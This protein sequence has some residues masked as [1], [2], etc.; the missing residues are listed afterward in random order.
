MRSK[1]IFN[2]LLALPMLFIGTPALA[3]SAESL[4]EADCLTDLSLT[5]AGSSL[6]LGPS[7]Y[8]R[9]DIRQNLSDIAHHESAAARSSEIANTSLEYKKLREQLKKEISELYVL[10]KQ[11]RELSSSES[12]KATELKRQIA[13]AKLKSFITNQ[14]M[15]RI[16][17]L[18][19]KITLEVRAFYKD[20]ALHDN[21]VISLRTK[22]LG[23]TGLAL[24]GTEALRATGYWSPNESAVISSKDFNGKPVSSAAANSLS[25]QNADSAR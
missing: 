24:L 8:Y 4:A 9:S 2:L 1:I 18:D 11:L 3:C 6:L 20:M 25:P 17:A 13:E 5:A 23:A 19:S 14:N 21:R 12:N 22:L 16:E 10:E 7:L 15:G